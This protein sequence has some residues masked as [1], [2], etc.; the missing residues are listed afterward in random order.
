MT[1]PPNFPRM[2]SGLTVERIVPAPR[3]VVD[4][5]SADGDGGFKATFTTPPIANAFLSLL[6]FALPFGLFMLWAWASNTLWPKKTIAAILA[7][8]GDPARGLKIPFKTDAEFIVADASSR[9]AFSLDFVMTNALAVT[10]IAIALELF[11]RQTQGTYIPILCFL[12][13]KRLPDYSGR[14]GCR[15]AVLI[16][17][18]IALG[19]AVLCYYGWDAWPL[20]YLEHQS[21]WLMRYFGIA[22]LSLR[23]DGPAAAGFDA[24]LSAMRADLA[25][26]GR[27]TVLAAVALA[28]S[29]FMASLRL[30][31]KTFE[32]T[33]PANLA[34]QRNWTIGIFVL[35]SAMLVFDL[36]LNKDFTDWL[37]SLVDATAKATP[38]DATI[39]DL[40]I[41]PLHESLT[42]SPAAAAALGLTLQKP[43]DA[44]QALAQSAASLWG[45]VGSTL[46]I[47]CAG[48]ALF[49]L[50]REIDAAAGETVGAAVSASR[51]IRTGVLTASGVSE[52]ANKIGADMGWRLEEEAAAR[53]KSDPNHGAK[54]KWKE[55]NG[56]DLSASQ[57][58]PTLL[59]AAAPLLTTSAINLSSLLPH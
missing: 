37:L 30:A 45:A 38:S 56:L 43:A 39:F 12:W 47:A 54:V 26:S 46:L 10:A 2:F 41:G 20:N 22:A 51:T 15:V 31:P 8:Y 3:P 21:G 36:R 55:D 5:A 57:I 44:L 6:C 59:A 58:I 4:H 11:R 17:L 23:P 49:A 16:Y 18:A 27:L 7:T 35:A 25:L 34:R 32:W 50:L 28:A 40:H 19:L 33:E 48:P 13:R 24:A 1:E 52:F 42:Q 9:L 29:A 14:R 53:R